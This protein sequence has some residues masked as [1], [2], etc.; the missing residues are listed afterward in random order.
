MAFCT[1]VELN[2][3]MIYYYLFIYCALLKSVTPTFIPAQV[4]NTSEKEHASN[5]VAEL[6]DGVEKGKDTADPFEWALSQNQWKLTALRAGPV[7]PKN[8]KEPVI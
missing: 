2:V 6:S 1:T 4:L 5:D 7:G 8:S 3:I